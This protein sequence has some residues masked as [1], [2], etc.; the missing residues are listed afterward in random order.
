MCVTGMDGSA[1]GDKTMV[2]I[3]SI[4]TSASSTPLRPRAARQ[5]LV[6]CSYCSSDLYSEVVLWIA[7]ADHVKTTH[8]VKK[9]EQ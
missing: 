8:L 9:S 2:E 4:S 1:R 7:W 6:V 3:Y 5:V